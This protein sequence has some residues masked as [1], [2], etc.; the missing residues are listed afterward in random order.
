MSLHAQ[1]WLLKGV[2]SELLAIFLHEASA[3][4]CV[5]SLSLILSD[6]EE[7]KV[8]RAKS[9]PIYVLLL[10]PLLLVQSVC[11]NLETRL[12]QPQASHSSDLTN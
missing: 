4:P 1:R 2:F 10:T 6:K 5:F 7:A 9:N 8:L 11:P 12:I 3:T